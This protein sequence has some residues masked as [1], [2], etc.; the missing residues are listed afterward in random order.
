[1]SLNKKLYLL[2]VIFGTLA[3]VTWLTVLILHQQVYWPYLFNIAQLIVLFFQLHFYKR[4]K[5]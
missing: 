1:M 3:I 4:Q 2:N 5:E